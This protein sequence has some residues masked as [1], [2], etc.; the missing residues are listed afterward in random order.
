MAVIRK[1]TDHFLL[2]ECPAGSQLPVWLAVGPGSCEFICEMRA[3]WPSTNTNERRT[4]WTQGRCLL[5]PGPTIGLAADTPSVGRSL[6]HPFQIVANELHL[7]EPD[8][9]WNQRHVQRV[10]RYR[11]GPACWLLA[12]ARVRTGSG[13]LGFSLTHAVIAS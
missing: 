13:G 6:A 5:V 8:R 1:P 4:D 9:E 11:Q 7:S 12:A 2:S 3:S 10:E